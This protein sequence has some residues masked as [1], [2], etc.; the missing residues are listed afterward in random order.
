MLVSEVRTMS[1][2][3]FVG[4]VQPGGLTNDF[5]VKILICLLLDKIA[6]P[7]TFDQINEILQKTGFVNYFEFAE[8]MSELQHSR[9]VRQ[10]TGPNGDSLFEI[11]E[12]GAATAQTFS[13]TLP[14]TV[15]EKTIECAQEYLQLKK[16]LEEIDIRY[17]AAPDGYI[18]TIQMKD[19]G[20]D[21][22]NLNVFI[23]TEEECIAIRERIYADPLILYQGI[24]SIL[25]GE[26]QDGLR[27]FQE[28]IRP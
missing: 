7:L 19:I 16:R 23:P 17:R 1:F 5:E 26:Y 8:S 21:L 18:L 4:G 9:H 6:Q 10:V 25:L 13:K 24:L 22:M 27:L 28:K 3:A 20:S 12:I 2:N 11:S 15:R 14:L